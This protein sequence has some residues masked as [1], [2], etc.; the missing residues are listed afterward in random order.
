MTEKAHLFI[1]GEKQLEFL[2][3]TL[4]NCY[5]SLLGLYDSRWQSI[6][7]LRKSISSGKYFQEFQEGFLGP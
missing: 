5:L 4:D 2:F 6:S 1:T 7:R 3:P